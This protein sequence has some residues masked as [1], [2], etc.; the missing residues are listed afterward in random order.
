MASPF[1]P[2]WLASVRLL[3]SS[4][5]SSLWPNP[6]TGLK[7]DLPLP[8]YFSKFNMQVGHVGGSCYSAGLDSVGQ[9]RGLRVCRGSQVR[10]ML[11]VLAQSLSSKVLQN[12]FSLKTLLLTMYSLIWTYKL[13]SKYWQLNSDSLAWHSGSS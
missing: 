6:P 3:I 5:T 13:I 9:E 12:S 1:G 2:T 10:L 11:L 4:S 8:L 7:S